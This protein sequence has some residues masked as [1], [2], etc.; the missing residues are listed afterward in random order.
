MYKT[1]TEIYVPTAMVEHI[2]KNYDVEAQ[3]MICVEELAELQQ[4]ISKHCRKR[5][6]N[7]P[8]EIAHSLI[9][10]SVLMTIYGIK[11]SDVEAEIKR[12]E[13]KLGI[14]DPIEKLIWDKKEDTKNDD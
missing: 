10:I 5:E 8:E 7:L 4:A 1:T 12:K 11:P 9:S 6:S 13:E 2:V 14:M 3:P